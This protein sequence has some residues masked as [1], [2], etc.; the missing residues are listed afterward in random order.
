MHT[1]YHEHNSKVIIYALF[2]RNSGVQGPSMVYTTV[3]EFQTK[4]NVYENGLFIIK[5]T[6]RTK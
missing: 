3:Q 5:F 1:T 2:S 6:K 4:V